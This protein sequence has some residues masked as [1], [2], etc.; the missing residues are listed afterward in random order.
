M[1]LMVIAIVG[2]IIWLIMKNTQ[3]PAAGTYKNEEVWNVEY[4]A[5]GMPTK[6]T[7]H[8]DARRE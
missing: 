7:I 8:R 3:K 4:S 2:L 1:Q 6:I 5:D